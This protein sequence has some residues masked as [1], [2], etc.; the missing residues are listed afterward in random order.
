MLSL[1]EE[2]W[3]STRSTEHT[4]AKNEKKRKDETTTP[5]TTTFTV[6]KMFWAGSNCKVHRHMNEYVQ[7]TC[8]KFANS[9]YWSGHFW[10]YLH[11]IIILNFITSNTTILWKVLIFWFQFGKKSNKSQFISQWHYRNWNWCLNI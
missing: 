8:R 9:V 1:G 11:L 3:E 5:T 4:I 6:A 10:L 2:Q 7:E